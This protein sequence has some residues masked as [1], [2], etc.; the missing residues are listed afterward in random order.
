[1]QEEQRTGLRPRQTEHI[2]GHSICHSDYLRHN[3]FNQATRNPWFSSYLAGSNHLPRTSWL[4]QALVY[5]EKKEVTS[6]E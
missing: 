4:E 1:M 3:N 5:H 6:S 2:P